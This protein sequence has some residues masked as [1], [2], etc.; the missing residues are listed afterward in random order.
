MIRKSIGIRALKNDLSRWV[1]RVRRGQEVLVTD[2]GRPV[3]RLV[4]VDE[5]G[6]LAALVAAGLVQPA[7]ERRR[8]TRIRPRARLRGK[9][10]TLS[11][12][13]LRGRR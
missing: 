7:P 4:P 1:A 10:P 9:G 8:G 5:V 2:R 12:Y 6:G 3:A 11:D 13:V